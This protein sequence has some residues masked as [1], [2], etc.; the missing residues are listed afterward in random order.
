MP[1]TVSVTWHRI[2]SRCASASSIYIAARVWPLARRTR[3]TVR[4]GLCAA[5]LTAQPH[6]TIPTEC[7]ASPLTARR[8]CQPASDQVTTASP[9]D[10]SNHCWLNWLLFGDICQLIASPVVADGVASLSAPLISR[11]H[12]LHARRCSTFRNHGD[13]IPAIDTHGLVPSAGNTGFYCSRLLSTWS[14]YRKPEP[15]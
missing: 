4:G 10:A 8:C 14:T 15:G 5:R 6:R 12:R 1:A 9:W 13:L 11:Q 2:S 3:D 7:F